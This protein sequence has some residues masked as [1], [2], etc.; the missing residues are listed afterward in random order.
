MEKEK[1]VIQTKDLR[2]V[3]TDE[4]DPWDKPWDIILQKGEDIVIGKVSFAGEKLLGTVPLY[5]EIQ[6]EYRGQGYGTSATVMMVEWLF[7]FR[8]VY[9]VKA[10]AAEK[11]DWAHRVLKSA[12]F[13]YRESEGKTEIYSIVKQKTSWA[14]LYLG[15][16]FFAGLIIGIVTDHTVIGLLVGVLIGEGIGISMDLNANKERE[17]VTGK[18][19]KA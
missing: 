8:N 15:I 9:E 4:T 17:K 6:K 3:P 12:G 11:D 14:G 18:K 2:I 13:V 10:S 5:V 19:E 16:G 7:H 1:F